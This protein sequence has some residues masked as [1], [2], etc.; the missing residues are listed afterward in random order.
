[1][2]LQINITTDD[3]VNHP[4]AYVKVCMINKDCLDKKALVNIKIWHNATARDGGNYARPVKEMTFAI[5]TAAEGI[6]PTFDSLYNPSI[7]NDLGM[8]DTKSTYN[9]MKTQSN[10]QGVDFTLSTDL[11]D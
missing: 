7:L 10:L 1:M 3:T 6:Y 5:K 9:W 2:A 4:Q 11:D 8:N